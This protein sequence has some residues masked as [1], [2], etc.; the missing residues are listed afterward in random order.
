[1]SGNVTEVTIHSFHLEKSYQQE[2]MSQYNLFE[3]NTNYTTGEYHHILNLWLEKAVWINSAIKVH[4]F[5][6]SEDKKY[7]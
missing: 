7:S 5:M 3:H 4:I 6:M 1:M 2:I